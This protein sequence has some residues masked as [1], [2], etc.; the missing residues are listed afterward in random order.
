MDQAVDTSLAC[1]TFVSVS[2]HSRL[3]L[4]VSLHLEL[5]DGEIRTQRA[6]TYA[7]ARATKSTRSIWAQERATEG[8]VRMCMRPVLPGASPLSQTLSCGYSMGFYAV[9]LAIDYSLGQ[10]L[11]RNSNASSHVAK[12]DRATQKT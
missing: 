4:F 9:Y 12:A 7:M 1:R 5:A 10:N 6:S 11:L 2:L 8:E 3:L